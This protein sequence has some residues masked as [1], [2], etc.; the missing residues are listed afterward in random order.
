MTKVALKYLRDPNY[1][2]DFYKEATVASNL[3]HE[4]IVQF[5]GVSKEYNCIILELMEG[6]QLLSYLR[7]SGRH[8][9][10][11]LDLIGMTNDIVSGCE[12][13]Q[14]RKYVHR[15]LA[16]RNCMMTSTNGLFRKVKIFTVKCLST[17]YIF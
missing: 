6:G 17:T 3:K 7:A 4:N 9:L 8:E 13:L 14:E 10:T 16:A 12:Y 2:D 15:D 1:S 11:L 5:V